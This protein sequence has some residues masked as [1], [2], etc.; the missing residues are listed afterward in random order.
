MMRPPRPD[1]QPGLLTVAP[2]VDLAS[3]TTRDHVDD[4]FAL[5]IRP[6]LRGRTVT[7]HV[8]RTDPLDLPDSR[9]LSCLR[10]ALADGISLQLVGAP[11]A[12]DAWSDELYAPPPPPRGGR[13]AG[14]RLAVCR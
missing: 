10:E 1:L 6:W 3:G 5:S 8:G 11:R 9:V 12:I 7:V 14:P 13:E 4:V 2:E